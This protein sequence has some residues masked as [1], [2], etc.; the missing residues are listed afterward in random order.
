MSETNQPNVAADLKRI[1]AVITRGLAVT[2]EKSQLFAE[3]GIP[4]SGTG[5]GFSAYVRSLES[6]LQAHH[7][8]EDEIAFPYFRELLPEAPY[9]ALMQEHGAMEP[10][11]NRLPALVEEIDSA[12]DPRDSLSGLQSI[13]EELSALWNVHISREEGAFDI[14]TVGTLLEPDE[15][16]RVSRMLAEHSMQNAGPDFWVVPFILYN[17]PADEREIMAR[18]MPPVVTQE[19]VPIAWKDKWGPMKP[20]LLD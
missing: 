1:H 20:F 11:L 7:H 14:E 13:L 10:L 18:G 5:Q 19:L 17:L 9:G 12:A 2:I 6:I 3:Q 4:D 16:L 15:H 8:A